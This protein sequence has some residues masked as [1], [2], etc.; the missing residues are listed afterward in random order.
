MAYINSVEWKGS[1]PGLERIS[2]LCARLGHPE[3][4]DISTDN[5]EDLI[6]LTAI[7]GGF[8]RLFAEKLLLLDGKDLSNGGSIAL[9]GLRHTEESS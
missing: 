6:A 9:A 8:T 5:T 3:R 2:E 4:A 1:R 7:M